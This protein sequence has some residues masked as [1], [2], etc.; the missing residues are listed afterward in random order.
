M[1][2]VGEKT[3]KTWFVCFL[4]EK[5]KEN[6]QNQNKQT[7]NYQKTK[8]FT[9]VRDC[10]FLLVFVFPRSNSKI[11]YFWKEEARCTKSPCNI[12]GIFQSIAVSLQKRYFKTIFK[13]VAI[14]WRTCKFM[15]FS[16]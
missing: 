7:K 2:V 8:L 14:I 16:K 6:Q 9:L 13:H 4:M 5:N 10:V 3:K 11:Q 12:Q 15:F 1:L